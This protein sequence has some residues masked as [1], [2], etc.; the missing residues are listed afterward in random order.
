VFAAHETSSANAALMPEHQRKQQQWPT[1]RIIGDNDEGQ[2]V[3]ALS[4][5]PL[6]GAEE[7]EPLIRRGELPRTFEATPDRFRM[8]EIMKDVNADDVA[9]LAP[10]LSFRSSVFDRGSRGH[11]ETCVGGNIYIFRLLLT[12]AKKCQQRVMT[13]PAL[14]AQIAAP[15]LFHPLLLEDAGDD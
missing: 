14:R 12:F 9:C 4:D 10:R 15:E 8:A 13:M 1:F 2:E 7:I 3:L 6:P 11:C 5:L